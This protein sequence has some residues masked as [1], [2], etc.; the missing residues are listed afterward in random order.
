[1][2]TNSSQLNKGKE[3]LKQKMKY[4]NRGLLVATSSGQPID[5]LN[6]AKDVVIQNIE[7][8]LERDNKVDILVKKSDNINEISNTMMYISQNMRNRES[9]RKN[10]YVVFII[11]LFLITLILI[12]I[13][14]F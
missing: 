12:Y 14:A 2:N 9:E 13:F 3:I 1:M 7:S 10:R 8:L 6:L 5:N 11:S 4:Y